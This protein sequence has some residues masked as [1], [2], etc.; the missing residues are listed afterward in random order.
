[1]PKHVGVRLDLKAGAGRGSLDA[2]VNG[3]PASRST[4]PSKII[5]LHPTESQTSMPVGAEDRSRATMA[6]AVAA[7]RLDHGL[8]LA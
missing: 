2:E 3:D 4:A 5:D 7:G 1:M 8:D 6:I